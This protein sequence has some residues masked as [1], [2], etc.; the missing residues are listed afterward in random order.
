[1]SHF[2]ARSQYIKALETASKRKVDNIK[3]PK[4]I[5]IAL[6]KILFI[7]VENACRSQ[8]AEALFNKHASGKAVAISAGTKPAEQVNPKAVEVM[9]EIGIDIS[10]QKPKILTSQMIKE[11]DRI[12]TMGCST[13][14]CPAPHI[15]TEDWNIEDPSGKPITKFREVRDQI[16]KKVEKLIREIS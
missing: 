11:A 8:I 3:H 14:F 4:N 10:K 7:C 12:V 13:D 5:K 2:S 15:K 9:K 6:K 1:M 16:K